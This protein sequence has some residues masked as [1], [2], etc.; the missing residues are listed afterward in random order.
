MVSNLKERLIL[1]LQ[2]G[3]LF[4]GCLAL[5][6]LTFLAATWWF[7]W[8]PSRLQ[9]I[10]LMIDQTTCSAYTGKKDVSI[11]EWSAETRVSG[12]GWKLKA[13]RLICWACGRVAPHHC[14]KV[15]EGGNG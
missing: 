9:L 6:F 12:H 13:A 5:L 15:L 1:R 7:I 3:V 4:V 8:N 2:W 10:E 14:T 11:S